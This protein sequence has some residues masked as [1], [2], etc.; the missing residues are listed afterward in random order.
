[1]PAVPEQSEEFAVVAKDHHGRTRVLGPYPRQA[2]ASGVGF[3]RFGPIVFG[4]PT[5]WSVVRVE[6]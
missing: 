2:V 4:T 5:L 6:K 3:T 1:M